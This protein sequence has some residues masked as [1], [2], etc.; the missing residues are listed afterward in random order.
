MEFTEYIYE[1]P[2]PVNDWKIFDEYK[3]VER[4][5]LTKA[6]LNYAGRIWE[7]WFFNDINIPNGSDVFNGLP[8]LIFEL[9]DQTNSFHFTLI[10]L[11]QGVSSYWET[12]SLEAKEVYA[13]DFAKIKE[14]YR[15]NPIFQMETMGAVIDAENRKK[16]LDAYREKRNNNRMELKPEY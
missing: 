7:A 8:G 4:N 6:T 16:I 9:R 3:E 12:S 14:N 10:G 5:I 2:N 15:Q 1:K 13:K 11:K